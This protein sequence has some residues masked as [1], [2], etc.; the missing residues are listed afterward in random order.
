M[1]IFGFFTQDGAALVL[2]YFRSSR[3]DWADARKMGVMG[4][5]TREQTARNSGPLL[6]YLRSFALS[7]VMK[8]PGA[9][10]KD[11]VLF[12]PHHGS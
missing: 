11:M 12:T 3:W 6:Q 9:Y 1:F 10:E 8:F 4:S 7:A 5:L 2:G